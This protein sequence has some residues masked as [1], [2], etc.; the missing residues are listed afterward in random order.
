MSVSTVKPLDFDARYKVAGYG[1]VAFWLKGWL[2]SPE[3]DDDGIT[4]GEVTVHDD[5]VEAVMVGDDRP[6]MVDVDDLTVINDDDYC[7]E[8]GQ[9]GCTADGRNSQ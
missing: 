3:F 8:C 4:T 1:G 2:T 6:I 5:F 9:I 7:H